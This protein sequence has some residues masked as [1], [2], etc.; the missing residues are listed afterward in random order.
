LNTLK[1]EG[2]VMK[3]LLMVLDGAADRSNATQTPFQ[4]AIKP[5]I[6]RLA[7]N[8]KVGM[9]DIGYKGSVE[10]DFGFLNLLGFYSKNTY[11]GRGYLEALGAGIEPKHG[12]LCIRGNFA[13]LN[14]DGN[15][16]DRRAGRDETGLE[17]LANMLD[18][19]EIDGVHFTVKK[20][21][22][23]R[24]II[25]ASGKNLSTELMPNDTREI[26]T[27]VRQIVAK[28]EKAKFTASVLNKFITRSR[29]LLER[30]EINKKRSKP[31]NVILMRGFGKRRDIEGFEKRYGM[32]ACCIAGIPI[33][34]GVARWLGMDVIE[35][36]GATGMP[37]TN[38]AGKFNAAIKAIDK[39]D[40][41]W[42]H[43]NACDIL[44]HDGKREEKRRYIEKID[45]EVG[46]LLKRI[47]I[48]KLIIAITSDHRTVSIPEF[49][50]YR[51]VPDPVPVLIAGN[52]IEAD[53]VGRFNEIDAESGSLKLKGNELI[54]KII[55]L[56][57]RK[58]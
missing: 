33:A 19:M 42:L 37:N 14:A 5:N 35:V 10:S 31:A 20:S 43:I 24:V 13:T 9:I 58:N 6:D 51:H 4:A 40:F 30:H 48:S 23:H 11:P 17:E 57:K 22:G 8:G 52:G 46:K 34:K 53:K 36:E 16:I 50:F 56:C 54:G 55:S 27:P 29:K 44:S 38:L 3:I 2:G 15:L 49:K 26:N 47:D 25:I 7:K 39:Y 45:S 12:D 28:N 41:I 18:G 32:K 1:Y 21:A